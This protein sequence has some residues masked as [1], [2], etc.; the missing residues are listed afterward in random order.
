MKTRI[1]ILLLLTLVGNSLI[2]QKFTQLSSGLKAGRSPKEMTCL[3]NKIIFSATT[4]ADCEE[5]WISDGTPTGT[6]L[7]KDIYPDSININPNSSFPHGFTVVN[8][9]LYFVADDAESRY[10]LWETDGT[11][12]GTKKVLKMGRDARNY[13]MTTLNGK[14]IFKIDSSG[15][16]RELFSY[17][18]ITNDLILLKDIYEGNSSAILSKPIKILITYEE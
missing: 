11:E 5:L 1:Q 2:A 14:F 9:K 15:L 7:L 6:T 17:D 13:P 4:A 18:P 3:N 16:G 8:N 12:E 10:N